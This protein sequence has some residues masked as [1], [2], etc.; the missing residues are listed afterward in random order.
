LKI[1]NFTII[2]QIGQGGY[3]QVFLAKKNDTKEICALKKMEKKLLYK[4]GEVS[5]FN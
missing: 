3:G 4:L 5:S 1:T 2:K